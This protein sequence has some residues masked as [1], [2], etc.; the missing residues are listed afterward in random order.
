MTGRTASS[1]TVAIKPTGLF[2]SA[3]SRMAGAALTA[4]KGSAIT[5]APEAATKTSPMAKTNALAN[6][7]RLNSN[8][9]SEFGR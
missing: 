3:D 2:A 7:V 8:A 5:Q 4:I 1:D 9:M 6:P